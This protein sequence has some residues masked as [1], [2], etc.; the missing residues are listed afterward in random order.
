MTLTFRRFNPRDRSDC[1][2]VF[3]SNQPKF[4][5]ESELP[6]FEA[7]IDSAACPFFVVEQECVIV[8]CGGYG[9]HDGSQ[10][11][12]LCWGMVTPDYHGNHLREYLLLARLYEIT[13]REQVNGVRLATS[14]HT[15]GF[16]RNMGR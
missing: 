9:I 11:A 4:F 6:D 16:F 12:D 7:F 14:Q 10:L 2:R 1:V 5:R 8:G 13:S 3:G 15:D